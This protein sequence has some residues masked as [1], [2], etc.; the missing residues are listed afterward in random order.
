[1]LLICPDMRMLCHDYA[2]SGEIKDG[3]VSFIRDE[4]QAESS[5]KNEEDNENDCEI[6]E[7]RRTP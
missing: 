1:M 3:M 2:V 4:R 7:N 6:M 5:V